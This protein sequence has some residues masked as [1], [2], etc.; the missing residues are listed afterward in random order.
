MNGEEN[1]RR[2]RFNGAIYFPVRVPVFFLGR[3][4]F[5]RAS[6]SIAGY[7][8]R[9]SLVVWGHADAAFRNLLDCVRV[10]CPSAEW[11]PQ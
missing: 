4:C 8:F 9:S 10:V 5:E 2:I 6:V 11:C 7:E 1:V 3:L